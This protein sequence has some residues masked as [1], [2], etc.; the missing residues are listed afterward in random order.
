[1]TKLDI[2]LAGVGG[3]GSL[4]ASRI[5]GETATRA[6][7]NVVVGEIHGMAQ[8]G[9]VVESTVRIGDVHGPIVDDRGADVLL[10]F[11]PVETVRA[12]AKVG[13]ETLVITST[14]PI[15][16]ATLALAGENYPEVEPLL[17]RILEVTPRLVSLDAAA[18]AQEAGAAQAMNTV[19]LGV[20]AG[21][22]ELPFPIELLRETILENVPPRAHDVNRRAF[23]AGLAFGR[24]A[25]PAAS[26]T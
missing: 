21:A 18:L 15:V 20:L 4:T 13:P 23:E 24:T 8:R 26:A 2:F 9:G 11:E 6:G 1:M 17:A 7:L 12:L 5:L 16:P 25:V 22:T 14:R 3:Q 10:G 19:L